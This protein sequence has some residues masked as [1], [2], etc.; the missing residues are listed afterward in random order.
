[1][2][3]NKKKIAGTMALMAVLV[4][5]VV[6][7]GMALTKN[8]G[9]SAR[10][11]SKEEAL[12][13]LPKLLKKIN[14][15]EVQPRKAQVQIGTS[16]L[17]DELPDISKYPLSV[18]GNGSI[19]IEIFSSTEKSSKGTDGWLNEVA[20]NFNEERFEIDGY[21]VSVSV[22][23]VASGLSVDYIKSGKY[24][25]EV[26]TPSN[27][28]WGDMIEAEGVEIE[29]VDES[30]VSNTAGILVDKDTYSDIESKY[31]SVSINTVIQATVDG[32]I[33]MGYTNPYASST[34]L[35]F[36]VS[37]LNCFDNNDILST[38]AV[39][40][41]IDFQANVPF[42][43][44]TTL[45]MR[46]AAESGA[47]DA[48]IMENQ[49]VYNDPSL[50]NYKFIPFGVE[51][52]N[53]VY[54]LGNLSSIKQ[55][56]LDMFVDYCKNSES[57][58]LADKYGFNQI[59]N[60]KSDI[61]DIAGTSLISAQKLWKEEKDAG[62]PVVAVFVADTS[63]SMDGEPIAQLKRSLINASQ[64]IGEDNSIG[65]V[66]Y[67]NDVQINLPIGKFDINHRAYFTGA[68]EDMSPFGSTATFDG[69]AVAADMLV[70][71]REANPDAKI[72]MFVLSDGETNIGSSLKDVSGIIQA[73]EI[74]IY[75]I[76]YNA[77]L[78]EL[79]KLSAINE[80]ASV[81][82][83]SDDVVYALKNLFNAQV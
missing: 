70:K 64:Y 69:V 80:A 60:Y 11:I 45:Q 49:T 79:S 66:T 50:K 37:A 55:E 6:G 81:N 74:P 9:K 28:L 17:I 56:L 39:E 38:K 63:G 59:K 40:S 1:M 65:L 68:V 16:S 33:A 21:T 67:N 10:E 41:F 25:P 36:L 22:R 76:G 78:D 61:P 53:P 29:L 32:E 47:L 48:F 24:V 27:E 82:A 20:E 62:R 58:E 13:D 8:I 44:Y 35:N 83:D 73:L 30:I 34:G 23:P 14:V 2:K 7:G 72:M 52:N 26:F 71:A 54:A 77:N 51:H 43:A 42:V 18:E 19:D 31:G 3:E 46:E 15:S 12:E 57:Q 5:G 4:T 75:T